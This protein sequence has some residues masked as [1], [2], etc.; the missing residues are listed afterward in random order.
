MMADT[1]RLCAGT[2]TLGLL[3]ACGSTPASPP[4][5][6]LNRMMTTQATVQRAKTA[7]PALFAA[8][9]NFH[10]RANEA[11]DDGDEAESRRLAELGR[12]ALDGA[13]EKAKALDAGRREASAQARIAA[14][15][16]VIQQQ[17]ARRAELQRRIER[18]EKLAALQT[19]QAQSSTR[20]KAVEIQKLVA[21]AAANLDAVTA[22]TADIGPKKAAAAAAIEKANAALQAGDHARAELHANEAVQLAQAA[23]E[24]A[25]RD[26]NALAKQRELLQR[27]AALVKDTKL[28]QRG[29]V[30]TLRNMFKSG[31]TVIRAR[32]KD[33]LTELSDLALKYPE[34][35]IVVHGYTD[36]RGR[37]ASNLALS[38]GRAQAVVE[39]MV[40]EGRIP[41][42]RIKGA[43]FG[44]E[45][46]IADNST[47]RGRAKNRRVE[48]IFLLKR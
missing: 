23:K 18:M 34:F 11:L 14:A 44:E 6:A 9:Q 4:L 3:W 48:V 22:A 27:S 2:I 46:P 33:L 5:L 42:E 28:D 26:L 7:D 16:R 35:P 13:L 29:V 8:G 36:S 32:K 19:A 25:S 15:E 24:E 43:G 37:N 39:Y 17:T 1:R 40:R 47:R 10:R 41:F 31:K 38:T 12:V 30:V 21:I 45:N 20:Q